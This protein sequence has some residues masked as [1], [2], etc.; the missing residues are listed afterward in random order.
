MDCDDIQDPCLAAGA[1][2]VIPK[3]QLPELL[4]AI[5]HSLRN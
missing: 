3:N 2:A 1:S 5:R 4:S